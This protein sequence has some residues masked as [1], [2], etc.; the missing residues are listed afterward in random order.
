MVMPPCHAMPFGSSVCLFL[1][2]CNH[3]RRNTACTSHKSHSMALD[4]FLHRTVYEGN[5]L[6]LSRINRLISLQSKD[7]VEG[8]WD[9]RATHTHTHRERQ[10]ILV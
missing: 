10:D 2:G 1:C 5:G 8:T 7:I 6:A 3:R 4:S 9:E